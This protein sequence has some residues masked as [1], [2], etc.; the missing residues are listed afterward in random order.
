MA[1][2]LSLLVR[3]FV[4]K[5]CLNLVSILM[6]LAAFANQVWYFVRC[7]LLAAKGRLPCGLR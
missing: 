1:K 6:I 4:I 5:I 3:S 2:V 7:V